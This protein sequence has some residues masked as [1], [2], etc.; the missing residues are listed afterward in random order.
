[1]ELER[2]CGKAKEEDQGAVASVLDLAKAFERVSLPKV[3]ATHFSFLRK[4]LRVLCGQ[5]ELQERV[6]FEGCV[7]EPP[8]RPSC[9][10]PGGVVCFCGLC[11]RMH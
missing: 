8:F 2:F 11:C 5:F 9:H 10:G 6:Q 7:A 4:I 1:M 3:W